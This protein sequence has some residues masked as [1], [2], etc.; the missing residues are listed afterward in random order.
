MDGR[1]GQEISADG[2]AVASTNQQPTNARI[3]QGKLID[4]NILI[5]RRYTR[6]NDGEESIDFNNFK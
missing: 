2:A 5:N 1:A 6:V 4:W 3:A